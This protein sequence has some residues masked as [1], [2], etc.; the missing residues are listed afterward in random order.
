MVAVDAELTAYASY[1]PSQLDAWVEQESMTEFATL[2]LDESGER[3]WPKPWGLSSDRFYVLAGP[4]LTPD[5]DKIAHE[6]IPAIIEEFFPD[7]EIRPHELHYSE[8][9]CN[10][11]PY[12]L[13]SSDQKK[14]MADEVWNLILELK[15]ALMASVV[16]KAIL[17]TLHGQRAF[18]PGDYA[19]RATVERF[20]M[21]MER[22]G[23]LGMAIID[24]QSFEKE[25]Q[26]MVHEAKTV[27]IKIGGPGLR[28]E[29]DRKLKFV[30]NSVVFSPSYMSPGIQLADYIAY[31]TRSHFERTKSDRFNK[32]EPLWRKGFNFR[33]PS[34]IPRPKLIA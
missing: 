10:V 32:L 2:Y 15:P 16:D 21:D 3:D 29:K 28:V 34:C 33:E 26:D 22:E 20:D 12:Q 9:V 6:R 23:K 14:A 1:F 31:A 19:V 7:P 25:I 18:R 30:L 5:Q 27:G 4:V 13:L 11:E 24:V 17:K 8:L